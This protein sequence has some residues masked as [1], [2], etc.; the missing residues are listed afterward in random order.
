MI[1]D[2]RGVE[3]IASLLSTKPDAVEKALCYR[4][5][6]NK[7]G[8]VEKEHTLEQAIYGRDALA[9][10]WRQRGRSNMLGE[11]GGRKGVMGVKGGSN[12]GGE[13]ERE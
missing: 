7:L 11:R 6:G 5:V 4:V 1:K 2:S 12:V 10:V 3:M 8:A 9:K 13:E